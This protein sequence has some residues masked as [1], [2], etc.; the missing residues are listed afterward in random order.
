MYFSY[1]HSYVIS[2]R[3]EASENH[4]IFSS[5]SLAVIRVC[6]LVISLTG[7]N[8]VSIKCP[9]SRTNT[10]VYTANILSLS[11]GIRICGFKKKK[12]NILHSTISSLLKI[13]SLY[14]AYTFDA[15]DGELKISSRCLL[16]P[17]FCLQNAHFFQ[18]NAY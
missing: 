13:H 9:M 18:F 17:I 3:N 1:P 15:F 12:K 4:S 7:W 11:Y 6:E 2:Y 10:G 16:Y 8:W 5:W 14:F